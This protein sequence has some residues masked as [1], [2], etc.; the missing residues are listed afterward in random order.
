M[1]INNKRLHILNIYAPSGS[2]H[3]QEREDLFKNQILY[4]LRN[5][6]SNTILCGDF[7][8]I[9]HVR[10]KTKKGTCPI[11]KSLQQTVKNLDLKDVWNCMHD[12]VEY[13]YFRENYGS[14]IDRIY[15]GDLKDKITSINVQPVTIS[16]HSC[17]ITKI[18]LD[19]NI[20]LGK[21]Y[22]KLN[23]KLL[24]LENIEEE[25]AKFWYFL[26]KEKKL[27]GNIN[28]WWEN[29]AKVKIKRFFQKKGREESNFKQG[30]IR[31][32]EW[33]LHK[34]YKNLH[35]NGNLDIGETKRYK[36]KINNLKEEILEGVRV[37][38]RI[39]E[40]VEGEVASSSLLGKQSV[41]KHKPFITEILTEQNLDGFE[42]N[43]KLNNQ[44]DI[45]KYITSYHENIYRE[46]A[47]SKRK[48]DW[49]LAFIDKIITDL[50][51]EELTKYISDEEI[52][53][54][55]KSFDPNKSP[56]IDGLPIEFYIKFF[57]IIKVEFCQVL[58]NCL[59]KNMLSESQ[60]KAIIILLFKGGD[61]NLIS[62]MR[63]I[64]L[65]CV[66]IKIL[67][68]LIAKRI[69]PFLHK[70]ISQ[71]QYCG[72]N[73]S[74]V[75]C[76]NATRDLIYYIYENNETGALIN[77]DLQRAFDS[78]DHQF[79]YKVLR[80]MGFSETFISWIKLFYK[81]IVSLVLVNGHQGDTF[82]IRRGVRQGCPLSM[83]LYIIA[84]EPLYQAIKKTHQIRS[85]DIPC[86]KKK[87]I[88]YADDSTFVVKSEL[89]IIYI[90]TI[91]KHFELASAVKLNTKKD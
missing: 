17:V 40:Q 21:F 11:S 35:E 66:D 42:V 68:K 79:L 19:C 75:D 33:K 3:H 43:T 5:N 27:Y 7:N 34:L 22:W 57:N 63:P 20:S 38:A 2:Q 54:I 85:L 83:I 36:D 90:F 16:D 76:N 31:Y 51:N 44:S 15:A 80:K 52:Y 70:C 84:Q 78:V 60:R 73:K 65:I 53:L 18:N 87:V 37:R 41:N 56:G 6:L 25:F 14:R 24:E 62:S 86:Q 47:T 67:S 30:L 61:C 8:C 82:K 9:T 46:V 58:R 26:C 74:I 29:C 55:I 50:D 1:S 39:K 48:Q 81:D 32:L 59:L 89:D 45:S 12:N 88:G 69:E 64:S 4:Y 10:D 72:K 77:I 28:E 13:T 49:F 71:E 91:L 23:N